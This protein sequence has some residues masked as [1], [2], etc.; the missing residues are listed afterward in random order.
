MRFLLRFASFLALTVAVLAGTIDSIQ[1]VA[2][3]APVMT[4]LGEGIEVLGPEALDWVQSLQRTDSGP[5]IWLAALHW[6]FMQPAFAVFLVIA[7][8][9]WMA[10]YRKKPAAG[11]FAA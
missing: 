8:L 11:R 4:P 7:L 10:G 1:S 3:S 2:A 6:L 5:A 9:F